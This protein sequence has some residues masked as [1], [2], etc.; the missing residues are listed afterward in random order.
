MT[1]ADVDRSLLFAVIALQDHL[2]DRDQLAEAWA[3]WTLKMDQ[4]MPDLLAHC[5]LITAEVRR[6]VDRR[7]EREL[8]EHRGDPRATLG[9]V[10]D[11]AT[12]GAI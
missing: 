8:T 3:V 5:G 10:A 12:R 11:A 7:M 2:I 1:D 9:A 4:P 6:E